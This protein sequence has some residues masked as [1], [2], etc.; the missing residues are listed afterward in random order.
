MTGWRGWRR[1]PL[2]LLGML[3]LVASVEGFVGRRPLEFTNPASLS[4][5]LS[6][7]AARDEAPAADVLCLGDSLIKHGALP[8]VIES[9]VGG[10]AC[11]LSVC[12]AQAPSTYFLFRRALERGARPRALVVDFAPDLLAGGPQ[13]QERCY[14]E[15]LSAREC[16]ELAWLARDSGFLARVA[17]GRL[18][19]TVRGRFEIRSAIL[20]AMGGRPSGLVDVNRTYRRNWGVN[21]G[22]EYT[23]PNGYAGEIAPETPRQYM[24]QAFACQKVNARYLTKLMRLAAS[25]QVPV[26]WLLPPIVPGLQAERDRSGAEAALEAFLKTQIE[27]H[28]GLTVLDARRAGVPGTRFVDAVHLNGPGGA[29]LSVGIGEALRHSA[30]LPRWTPLVLAPEPPAVALEDVA[31]SRTI[32]EATRRR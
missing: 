13:Y 25:R 29:A 30:P 24:A 19:P 7:A 20:S 11:N 32:V 8:R 14:Q 31:A 2:G 26:Y 4:W 10:R 1:A 21:G 5:T 12:A 18:L 9:V 27:R 6:A 22:A 16:L 3:A 28:A 15:L 23:P 17:L